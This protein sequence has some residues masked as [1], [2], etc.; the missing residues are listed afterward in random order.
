MIEEAKAKLLEIR[1]SD[2]TGLEEIKEAFEGKSITV[3]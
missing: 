3:I 1:E 2:Q